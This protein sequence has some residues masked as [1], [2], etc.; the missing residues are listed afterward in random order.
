MGRTK[1][2]KKVQN[3]ET[4]DLGGRLLVNSKR[5]VFFTWLGKCLN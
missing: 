1:Q 3:I 5:F 4:Y 2:I